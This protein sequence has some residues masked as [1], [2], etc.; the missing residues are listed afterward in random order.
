MHTTSCFVFVCL[1]LQV[2]EEV[3][4]AVVDLE[5]ATLPRPRETPREY[6]SSQAFP[7]LSLNFSG[8]GGWGHKYTIN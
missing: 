4:A 5:L 3:Q 1:L 8:G 2:L 6:L 7:V